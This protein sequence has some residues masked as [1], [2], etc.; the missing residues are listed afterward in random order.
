MVNRRLRVMDVI[1]VKMETC[2]KIKRGNC[3]RKREENSEK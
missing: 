2:K 1:K 3:M